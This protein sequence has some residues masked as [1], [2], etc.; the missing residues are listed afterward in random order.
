MENS[1]ITLEREF[2]ETQKARNSKGKKRL[3]QSYENWEP[4]HTQTF[5]TE[6]KYKVPLKLILKTYKA[7]KGLVT[8]WIY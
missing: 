2:P 6:L 4:L 7:R 8:S 5:K 3:N 1:F